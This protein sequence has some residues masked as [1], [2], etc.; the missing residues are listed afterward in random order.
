M[1]ANISLQG[2]NVADLVESGMPSTTFLP[3]NL[4]ESYNITEQAVFIINATESLADMEE[5]TTTTTTTTTTDLP[6]TT[7]TTTTQSPTTVRSEDAC[8]Q[9]MVDCATITT[10]T[11]SPP[12]LEDYDYDG[13]KRNKRQ[14]NL[15]NFLLITISLALCSYQ[16]LFQR[17]R[18]D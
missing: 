11:T 5:Y 1:K 4:S 16:K 9:V 17:R 3:F 2:L 7:T 18:R 14:I 13:L 12:L 15:G 6:T 10:T 8:F